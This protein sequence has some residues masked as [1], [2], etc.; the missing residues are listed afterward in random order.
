MTNDQVPG[1]LLDAHQNYIMGQSFLLKENPFL[2]LNYFNL[3]KIGFK[4]ELNKA[5]D[6]STRELWITQLSIVEQTIDILQNSQKNGN[7]AKNAIKSSMDTNDHLISSMRTQYEIKKFKPETIGLELAK[8]TLNLIV[9]RPLTRSD[10]WM[11]SNNPPRSL[12]LFGPPGCGKSLLATDSAKESGLPLYDVAPGKIISKWFGESEKNIEA[13]FQ[14]AHAEPEGCI[15][16]F[17]EFDAIAGKV[18]GE[19]EAMI[20]VRKA[21]LTALDGYKYKNQSTPNKVRV[22]ATTNRPDRLEGSMMRRFDRRVYIAPPDESTIQLLTSNITTR[23]GVDLDYY[24]NNGKK[25]IQSMLGLTAKEITNILH[26]AIWEVADV[27]LDNDENV[28]SIL[29][30]ISRVQVIMLTLLIGQMKQG[31]I[32]QVRHMLLALIMELLSIQTLAGIFRDL[33][34]V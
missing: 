28:S 8:Q 24:S 22:I 12:L 23:A 31:H 25:L 16:Y 27:I 32:V 29:L 18:Q 19:S 6:F 33:S 2:A 4:S 26:G 20:R 34:R 30:H 9:K 5:I 1:N 11:L 3:A 15:L 13:L 17:D 10:I 21:L 14:K 7:I